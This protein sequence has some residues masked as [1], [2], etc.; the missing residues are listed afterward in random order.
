MPGSVLTSETTS[1]PASAAARATATTS[2]TLGVSFTITQP[3]REGARR[4]RQS[5]RLRRL[6]ADREAAATHVRTGHVELVADDVGQ[7][8]DGALRTIVACGETLLDAAQHLEVVLGPPATDVDDHRHAERLRAQA[9]SSSHASMPGFCRP[10]ALI[11]P[12]DVS[13][14]RGGGLPARGSSVTVLGT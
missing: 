2:V 11:M 9:G 4:R 12:D 14:R 7:A 6:G 10:T 8:L 5:R 1:A 3:S 13:V